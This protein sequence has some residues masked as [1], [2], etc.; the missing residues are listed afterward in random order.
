ML[1]WL[2]LLLSFH[3][4]SAAGQQT[5]SL[6][7]ARGVPDYPDVEMSISG[8]DEHIVNVVFVGFRP[9]RA[10]AEWSLR[11]C[12]GTAAKLDGSRNIVAFLWYRERGQQAQE[13]MEPFGPARRLVYQASSRQLVVRRERMLYSLSLAYSLG[14]SR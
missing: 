6:H 11:D 7:C 2:L 3:A 8:R 1:R 9:S 12:L 10:R 13:L 4:A 14:S 5:V